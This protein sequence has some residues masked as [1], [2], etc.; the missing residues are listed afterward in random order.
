LLFKLIKRLTGRPRP[1][2]VDST[3]HPI[4][5]PPDYFSFPSGH[6][7]NAF[8]LSAVFQQFVPEPSVY[9][10]YILASGI[11]VSR[12]YLRL[13]YPT[14]VLIGSILGYLIGSTVLLVV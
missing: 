2:D 14:D 10:L 12:V 13:H 11:A 7:I 6:S 9:I 1:C 5:L 3:I 8:A 4:I